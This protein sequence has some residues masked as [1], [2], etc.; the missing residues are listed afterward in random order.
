MKNQATIYRCRGQCVITALGE[1]TKTLLVG[2]WSR[3]EDSGLRFWKTRSNAIIVH[4][5]VPSD[6]THRTMSQ[7]SEK[8]KLF[9]RLSTTR[10]APRVTRRSR[11][12]SQQQSQL[13]LQQPQ[14]LHPER[15]STSVWKQTLSVQQAPK[16]WCETLNNEF[17]N[18][19]GSMLI[20]E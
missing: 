3:S 6:V 18:N 7:N 14:Q 16:N 13:Q 8:K 17:R 5:R 2:K 19:L 20:T 4:F 1:T 9:R 10:L 12:Q 11:W 15:V